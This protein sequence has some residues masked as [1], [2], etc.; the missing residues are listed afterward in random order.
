MAP[1]LISNQCLKTNKSSPSQIFQNNKRWRNTS[2]SFYEDKIILTPKPDKNTI[3]KEN[4][5]QISLMN[6]EAKILTQQNASNPN[7]ATHYKRYFGQVGFIPGMH[8]WFDT[9]NQIM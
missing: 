6:T 9:R 1:L 4:Y 5:R 3:W 2:N 7:T 8:G